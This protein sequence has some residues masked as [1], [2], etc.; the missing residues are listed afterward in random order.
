MKNS[1]LILFFGLLGY[2]SQAQDVIEAVPSPV[3]ALKDTTYWN[4]EISAG[5]NFN[6]AA[7]SGNWKSGGVNSVAFGSI[8]S[9]KANYAKEKISWDNDLEFL[10][11][12]VKN[13]GQGTRKAADRI[14]LDSKLGYKISDHWGYFT[15]VNFISQF[16]DGF[17]YGDNGNDLLISSFLAPGFLTASLGLEY[18]PNDEF[19]LRLSPFSPRLTFVT[20]TEIINNVPNN[21]GVDP[22]KKVR[23]ELLAF[24]VYATWKKQISENFTIN[25]RYQ[26]FGNYE[27]LSFKNIDHRL[28][29]TLVA[30]I[31]SFI[32]VTFTSINLYDIDMDPGIQ[33]SQALALGVLY[34][35]SNKK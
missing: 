33:Y 30:K 4:S 16:A 19:A 14:F 26:M 21:Y 25:S 8:I 6:Q 5:L 20:N 29:V 17:E 34:K 7:F 15:A 11:G 27:T 35:I 28:D 10:F 22:G 18:K 32:D 12:I 23:G 31:T 13:E 1:I 3:T 9:G 24:L 2:A